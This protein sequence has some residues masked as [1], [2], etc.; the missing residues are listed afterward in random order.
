MD[1]HVKPLRNDQIWIEQKEKLLV[2]YK[3]LTDLD[4]YFE[5]GRKHE[6]IER[7]GVKL[8]KSEAEMYLIFKSFN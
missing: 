1:R 8:G 2:K 6:M 4:L 5:T 3:N 7:L